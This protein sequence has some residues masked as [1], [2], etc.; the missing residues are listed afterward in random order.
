MNYATCPVDALLTPQS[1]ASIR[2]LEL[3]LGTS[4]SRWDR[5]QID[6]AAEKQRLEAEWRE[7]HA[8]RSTLASDAVAMKAMGTLVQVGGS[9]RLCGILCSS[10]TQ[11][12]A[13]QQMGG[14]M[15]AGAGGW[16][17]LT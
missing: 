4:S 13:N 14:D 5:A 17:C 8:L 1:Q 12:L 15:D 11:E 10:C 9:A 3:A 7:V 6:F 16:S 2:D